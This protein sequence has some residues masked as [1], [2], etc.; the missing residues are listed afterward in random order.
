MARPQR[1]V[2]LPVDLALVY[3]GQE[4]RYEDAPPAWWFEEQER[5]HAFDERP[6]LHLVPPLEVRTTPCR[7][8]RG[9]CHRRHEHGSARRAAG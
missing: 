7:P 3:D 2:V 5:L 9:P 8:G 6:Q 4:W 1:V